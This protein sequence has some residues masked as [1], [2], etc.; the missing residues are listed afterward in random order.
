M[1]LK[2][3]LGR[4]RLYLDGGMGSMIQKR[5]E[6]PGSVPEGL[7]LTHPEVIAE[8]QAAYVAAGA[9]ILVANTFG[10]NG[11][12]MAGSPYSVAEVVRAAVRIAKAQHP[13]FVA[14]DIG[15]TGALIG[16]LGDLS[17]EAAKACFAEAVEAGA[18]AGADLILIE[19][20]TDIYEARAA[21]LAAKEHSDLPIICSMT[22]E[23]NGRTLTGS[24][25]ETVVTILEGLG[26]D[27]I[28]INCSTGPDQMMPVI[29]RLLEAASVP[30]VVEPNAGLPRVVD[31]ETVYDVDAATFAGFMR[32]IAAK[33][34]AVLGGCCGT[35]PDY[36]AATIAE[37]RSVALPARNSARR[38]LRIASSTRTVTLGTDIR[39]IGEAINPTTNPELKA[40]LRRAR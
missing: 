9:D 10:A 6:N 35:T 16:D 28:G 26:V 38:P 15:P 36:I 11:N 12:K 23:A 20:M 27:A 25:P 33:G 18:A 8:I 4:E 40:D 22:Y 29:D 24:D 32:E 19:T 30:I 31:G 34:A 2:K 39:V 5:I 21:V 17:F 14:M 13:R 37:T 1:E 7:N 3:I